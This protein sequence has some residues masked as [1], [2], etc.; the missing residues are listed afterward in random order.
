MLVRFGRRL[1]GE[2]PS[3]AVR[4]LDAALLVVAVVVLTASLG[5]RLA[6]PVV[7]PD[8][9]AALSYVAERRQPEQPILVALPAIAYLTPGADDGLVFL[10]GPA[11]RSRAER[12]TRLGPDGRLTDYWIGVPAITSAPELRRFLT[13]HPDAW[14]VVDVSRLE[15]DWAY[16]GPIADLLRSETRVVEEGPGH[17]LILRP[18]SAFVAAPMGARFR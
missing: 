7:H 5:W 14:I 2:G 11:D 4:R 3:P 9:R 17:V 16:D 8:H 6:H 15:G 18:R 1:A 13:S 10:A 12:L